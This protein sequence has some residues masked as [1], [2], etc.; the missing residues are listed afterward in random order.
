GWKPKREAGFGS[1]AGERKCRLLI[2][3]MELSESC[4]LAVSSISAVGSQATTSSEHRGVIRC[5]GE[6]FPGLRR[7]R[8][9]PGQGEVPAAT[10]VPVPVSKRWPASLNTLRHQLPGRL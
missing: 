4:P 6:P 1:G 9:R 10:R 7:W 5:E 8:R 2:D 3:L